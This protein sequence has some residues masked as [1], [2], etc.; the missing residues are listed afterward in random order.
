MP[1]GETPNTHAYAVVPNNDA[2]LPVAT[3]E[4]RILV[5]GAGNI[6]AD[7]MQGE[8]VTYTGLLAGHVYQ[9][10]IKKIYSTGTTATS[11]TAIY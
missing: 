7:T 1:A 10:P 8:T 5:G 6:R 2:N 11:L 4:M 9:L 3:R